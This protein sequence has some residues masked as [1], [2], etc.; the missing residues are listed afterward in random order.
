MPVVTFVVTIPL[1]ATGFGVWSLVV[2]PLAGNLAGAIAA[3]ARLAVPAA[4]A[5]RS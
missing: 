3:I 1:A 2:G 5:L 4:A